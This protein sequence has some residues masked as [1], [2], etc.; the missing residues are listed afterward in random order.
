MVGNVF[1]ENAKR[2]KSE[3]HQRRKRNGSIASPAVPEGLRERW[4]SQAEV[5]GDPHSGFI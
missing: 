1:K 5:G 4:Q 3:F 2:Y